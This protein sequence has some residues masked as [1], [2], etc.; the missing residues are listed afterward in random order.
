MNMAATTANG[1]V[2]KVDDDLMSA[3]RVGCMDLRYAKTV[4]RFPRDGPR[5]QNTDAR[6]R[7]RLPT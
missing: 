1:K 4:E 6:R 3:T 5:Q 2:V 7:H